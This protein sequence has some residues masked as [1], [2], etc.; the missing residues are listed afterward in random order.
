MKKSTVQNMLIVL[1]C[2]WLAM[3]VVVPIAIIHGKITN[4]IIYSGTLGAL[5]MYIVT[6]IPV[7]L[8]ASGAGILCIYSLDGASRKN[9][10]FFL[11]LLFAV[12]NFTSFHWVKKPEIIDLV[13]QGVESI[14]PA[15]SC[16][17]SGIII[18]NYIQRM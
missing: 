12:F 11:A 9:W 16:Y 1:G 7:A 6:A 10:L 5:L 8:S 14:I 4:G 15:I 18:F 3:W 2:Y 17:L 13:F